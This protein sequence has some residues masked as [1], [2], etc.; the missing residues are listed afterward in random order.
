[1]SHSKITQ[2]KHDVVLVHF[3]DKPGGRS[4]WIEELDY[5]L[6]VG[7]VFY[8]IIGKVIGQKFGPVDFSK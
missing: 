7:G 3:G 4:D 2:A 6:K 8:A 5:R 1:M